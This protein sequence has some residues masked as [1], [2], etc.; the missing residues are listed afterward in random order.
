M[1]ILKERSWYREDR[2]NLIV[3]KTVDKSVFQYG[4]QVPLKFAPFFAEANHKPLPERGE[5]KLF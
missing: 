1:A 4:T 5:T 3:I 2:P